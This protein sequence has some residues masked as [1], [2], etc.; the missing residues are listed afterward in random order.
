MKR[1]GFTLLELSIVLV[2]IGLI[3]GGITVGQELIKQAE[4]RS[5]VRDID[6][7]KTSLN[8][9]RMKYNALPGDF[10]RATQYWTG[11]ADGDANGQI[12]RYPDGVLAWQHMSLANV[13]PGTYTGT[14]TVAEVGINMP[15][16][17]RNLGFQM[18][19]ITLQSQCAAGNQWVTT[20]SAQNMIRVGITATPPGTYVTSSTVIFVPEIALMDEKVDDGMPAVGNMYCVCPSQCSAGATA[21]TSAYSYSSATTGGIPLFVLK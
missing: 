20:Y 10:S 11:T 14:G 18:D 9:F 2:I 12:F 3:I 19:Y 17:A 15:A 1:S 8:V 7:V 6:E 13:Y 16:S 21:A 5:L 4:M